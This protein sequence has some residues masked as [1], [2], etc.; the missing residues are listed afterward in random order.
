MDSPISI[1]NAGPAGTVGDRLPH[2][3]CAEG[4]SNFNG[5]RVRPAQAACPPQ[6]FSELTGH[7]KDGSAGLIDCL[8]SD[9]ALA[10]LH[11]RVPLP[12]HSPTRVRSGCLT[13]ASSQALRRRVVHSPGQGAEQ[14][15]FGTARSPERPDA[16]AELEE[17]RRRAI[18]FGYAKAVTESTH[19]A[20]A[21]AA[22]DRQ[23][24]KVVAAFNDAMQN[25]H[26]R[27]PGLEALDPPRLS[28]KGAPAAPQQCR[29]PHYEPRLS[30][31]TIP[32]STGG[33]GGVRICTDDVL[34]ID[35]GS[36]AAS[37]VIAHQ[38]A[39]HL[40]SE[41]F[42]SAARWRPALR[43]IVLRHERLWRFLD[44]PDGEI[45]DCGRYPAR[46]A[47]LCMAVCHQLYPDRHLAELAAETIAWKLHA[48]YGTCADA[49][50]MP[51]CLDTWVRDCFPFLVR[52]Q[53]PEPPGQP[54]PSGEGEDRSGCMVPVQA[55]GPRSHSAPLTPTSKPAAAVTSAPPRGEPLTSLRFALQRADRYRRKLTDSFDRETRAYIYGAS[56]DLAREMRTAVDH[57]FV[58]GM[59]LPGNRFCW[60][61]VTDSRF[62]RLV[63]EYNEV[64]EDLHTRFPGLRKIEQPYLSNT[65][66]AADSTQSG[67]G[68]TA[69]LGLYRRFA[70][71]MEFRQFACWSRWHH[72]LE[73][74]GT[75]DSAPAR[76]FAGLLAH[77]YGHHLSSDAVVSAPD[78][79]PPLKAMLEAN[80]PAPE[81]ASAASTKAPPDEAFR[82]RYGRLIGTMGIGHYAGQDALEFAAEAISWRLHRDYGGSSDAPRMPRYLENWVHACFPFL[83]NGRIPDPCVEVN[84]DALQMLVE[85]NGQ[86][87]W[88]PRNAR[89]AD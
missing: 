23:F 1:G 12:W 26:R 27:F 83:N 76:G 41:Q 47:K 20:M 19:P 17:Q 43:D 25:Y 22:S 14:R 56:G 89:P 61:P 72:A 42:V 15:R 63:T 68:G 53:S 30:A 81:A 58:R 75:R 54:A 34:S 2:C 65:D 78:W 28:R 49:P 87:A 35:T 55:D 70:C 32:A 84:P 3:A 67:P 6:Q 21:T 79:M 69:A 74:D 44:S 71:V 8:P 45:P 24:T 16:R 50:I 66:L 51:S 48:Q 9:A 62:W 46:V 52:P 82:A 31:I 4:G 11:R 86:L 59:V 7:C 88:A 5:R 10:G 36:P 73:S 39:H 80:L 85:R 29:H 33:Q 57:G 64:M 37:D 38:Y 18:R 40:T 77:E 13:N 60:H